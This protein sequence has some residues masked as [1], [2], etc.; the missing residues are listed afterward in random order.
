MTIKQ[1]KYLLNWRNYKM[2]II[3]LL[4]LKL[5][6]FK[7]IKEFEL[8]A[9]GNDINIFGDN[10]TGKT[11]L[12]DAFVWLLFNKDSSNRSTFDIKTLDDAGNVINK[13]DHEVEATLLVDG[14]E[15]TLKKVYKE[16]W[17][18]KRGSL[19]DSFTGHTTDYYINGVPSKKK[20]YDDKIAEIVDENV[21][22]LLTSPSHF[23][24]NLHWKERRDLLLE[25]AGDLTDEDVIK[26][27]KDLSKLLDALNGNS[28]DD[29]KKIIAA[30][31][32]EI[33]KKI[34]EIPTR[35]DEIH[36][37]L[38]DITNL[39][40]AKI[41]SDI[42]KLSFSIEE[43]NEQ[44]NKIR[45]GSETNEIKKKISDIELKI[46]NVRNEHTQNEQETLYKLKTRL[47]EE[48]SNLTI[49]RN[50]LRSKTEISKSNES[51]IK[52]I[53]QL[54]EE[55]RERY[56]EE[57]AKEFD[58]EANCKCPS[59]EQDLPEEQIK[60]VVTRF[61]FNKSE[62][63]EGINKEG[64]SLKTQVENLQ[65]EQEKLQKEIDKIA[66]Q[67]K[68]KASDI[69]K[70]EKKVSDAESS[71]KPIEENEQ[72]IKLND[73]KQKLEQQIKA[74]EQSVEESVG[75][76]NND[77]I[78][79]IDQQEELRNQLSSVEMAKKSKE[80]IAELDAEEKELA[81]EYEKLSEELHLTEEFTRI[82]VEMLT[83]NINEKFKYARFNLFEEQVNGGLSEVCETTYQGVPYSS[84][85]N[86][87]ARINV[88]LDIIDTL[89]KHYG[90]Q[91]PIFVD[92]SE[93][94]TS[95]IDIEAQLISLSVSEID[96]EL[97]VEAKAD[98]ESEVA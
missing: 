12:F 74:L 52:D 55:L 79:L 18:K 54:M 31:R 41:K 36:R 69:E 66:E 94:V 68:K 10:A 9:S 7:G 49:M 45:S 72:Y 62:K 23:N 38:P 50:D 53:E 89:S 80:R 84:G 47:Q 78:P 14:K 97:R 57:N 35:I 19:T 90:V 87:A 42:D 22:K 11:T 58:H 37:N 13:L 51:R 91:A 95:L 32:R 81:K 30:K 3:K 75:R 1:K 8:N 70:L 24:E 5:V 82:K 65:E 48:Q 64:I 6:N 85:L 40:E 61:N 73:E 39:D 15:L 28:V 96:K 86:N 93:S 46:N 56:V 98:K 63:L 27:N 43:K 33:N 67:G 4:H 76:V 71:V 44:I 77:I 59:C 29:H 16:Q 20:E 25:I 17:T 92:N 2:K 60:E 88:G 21:F 34:D 26:S 83:D